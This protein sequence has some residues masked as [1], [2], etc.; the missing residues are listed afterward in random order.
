MTKRKGKSKTSKRMK[1]DFERRFTAVGSYGLWHLKKSC[2]TE[3]DSGRVI[4]AQ[5]AYRAGLPVFYDTR[6]H[7]LLLPAEV[8]QA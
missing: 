3:E 2:Y 1:Y 5:V 4:S 6:L 7:C 8:A